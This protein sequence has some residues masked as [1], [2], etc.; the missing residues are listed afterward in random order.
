MSAYATEECVNIILDP[1]LTSDVICKRLPIAI[2]QN[3][4]FLV[5][6]SNCGGSGG[7]GVLVKAIVVKMLSVMR[8]LL[9]KVV[10]RRVVTV[11]VISSMLIFCHF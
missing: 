5:D 2:D 6:M 4:V 10:L 11:T 1:K 9:L 7:V 8:A 3:S